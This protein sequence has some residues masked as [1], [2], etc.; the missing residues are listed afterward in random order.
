MGF[1][2]NEIKDFPQASRREFLK[3]AWGLIGGGIGAALLLNGC[4]N[5]IATSTIDAGLD[6][7]TQETTLSPDTLNPETMP[8]TT[9]STASN[10]ATAPAAAST[11]IG[12]DT[13]QALV[14]VLARSNGLST[15]K[16][17]LIATVNGSS[18]SQTVYVKKHFMRIE[19]VS[20]GSNLIVLVNYNTNRLYKWCVDE[21]FAV[22]GKM[23]EAGIAAPSQAG[24]CLNHDPYLSGTETMDGKSCLK[25][26][27]TIDETVN[28]MWI[29]ETQGLPVRW[30]S[31]NLEGISV[32]E[33][34]NYD[35]SDVSDGIFQ[36]P[37][38]KC[39]LCVNGDLCD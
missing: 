24:S 11:T 17:D 13:N 2:T 37:D 36:L 12:S 5:P 16:Y 9:T 39:D 30:E 8:G 27:Y 7:M 21:K 38:D 3:T 31:H 33:Y 14:D 29:W 25:V 20:E 26:D 32:V 10:A 34:R 22:R 4:K 28:T 19:T 35:F 1:E 6:E 15:I 18:T 23:E